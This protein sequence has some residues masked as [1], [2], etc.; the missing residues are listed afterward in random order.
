MRNAGRD[1]HAYL[2]NYRNTPKGMT[3]EAVIRSAGKREAVAAL[4]ARKRKLGREI[5]IGSVFTVTAEVEA[6][7]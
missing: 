1:R 4:V 6:H 2:I 5:I 3:L 7:A